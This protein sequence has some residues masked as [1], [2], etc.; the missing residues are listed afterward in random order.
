MFCDNEKLKVEEQRKDKHKIS[1]AQWIKQAT[2]CL[3]FGVKPALMT[4][5]LFVAV[6][7]A[8]R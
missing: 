7:V 6:F 4:L 8:A 1:P 3:S 5:K 2:E